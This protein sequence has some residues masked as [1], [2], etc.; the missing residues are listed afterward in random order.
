MNKLA[1]IL[2]PAVLAFGL[3]FGVAAS[4]AHDL[5]FGGM[6][7]QQAHTACEGVLCGI[8]PDVTCSVHCLTSG[9][10]QSLAQPL[11][12]AL[13][14]LSVLLFAVTVISIAYPPNRRTSTVTVTYGLPPPVESI[15]TIVKRE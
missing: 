1:Y 8:L 11:V 15:L 5:V 4:G 2:I 12:S 9:L 3:F 10:L 7:M 6:N 13:P 14:A